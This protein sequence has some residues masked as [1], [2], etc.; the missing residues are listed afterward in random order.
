[1]SL[2]RT[3]EETLKVIFSKSIENPQTGCICWHGYTNHKGYGL[4]KYG[5]KDR[6]IHRVIYEAQVGDIPKDM[7]VL[8][9]CDNRRCVNRYHLF[10][11]TN[12]DNIDDKIRKD[13]SGKKLN[14]EKV[15]QIKELLLWGVS[16]KEIAVQFG[17]ARCTISHI[18]RGDKWAHVHDNGG[19]DSVSNSLESVT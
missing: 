18:N 1:M 7:H 19:T 14:I 5:G 15:K 9:T 6:S 10:L 3:N 12:R 16:Q 8:H 13:R 2:T 17:V 4:I 11:G